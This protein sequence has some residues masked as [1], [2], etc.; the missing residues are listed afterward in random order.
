[1]HEYYLEQAIE[2]KEEHPDQYED[3]REEFNRRAV[4]GLPIF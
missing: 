4:L 2:Y 1:M 3:E